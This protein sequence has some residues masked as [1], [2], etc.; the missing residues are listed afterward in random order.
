LRAPAGFSGYA[1]STGETTQQIQIVADGV[2]T[3][4]VTDSNG[5]ASVNSETTAIVTSIP[6]QPE[7]TVEGAL[8]CPDENSP[9]VLRA[10]AGYSAYRWS[11][12]ET[13]PDIEVAVAGTYTVQ[14]IDDNACASVASAEVIVTKESCDNQVLVYDAIS[15]GNKDDLNDHLFIKNIDKLPETQQN[16]LKIYNRW[17]DVVFEASNYDNVNNTFVGETNDGKELAGGTY[18]YVLEFKSRRKK[19]S[20]YVTLRR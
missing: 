14:V 11:G 12:G 4:R 3:V 7:V 8:N 2:Y 13:T 18:F 6:S 15:P 20:G 1:W 5:C 9:T 17:G 16:H 10:P 19:M